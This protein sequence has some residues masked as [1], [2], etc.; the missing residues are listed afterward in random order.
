MIILAL[1]LSFSRTGYA[2]DGFESAC[3]PRTGFWSPPGGGYI[4]GKAGHAYQSWLYR[5]IGDWNVERVVYEAPAAGNTGGG[6]IMKADLLEM[7]FGLAFSTQ[8]IAWTREIPVGKAHVQTVRKH[9]LGHGRPK[10]PKKHVMERCKTLGWPVP[11]HD[12][13][14]AAALWCW[15]K[16]TFDK[17]FRVETASPL[18]GNAVERAARSVA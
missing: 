8:V 4:V 6:I 18:F 9:F 13:A 7:L 12:A 5:A 2:V 16:A 17:S 3:P 15:A 10:N 14:D 1:D 11:N